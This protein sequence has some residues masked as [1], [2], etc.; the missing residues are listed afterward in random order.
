[1]DDALPFLAIWPHQDQIALLTPNHHGT[2]ARFPPPASGTVWEASPLAALIP[3]LPQPKEGSRW[4]LFLDAELPA[5]WHH[6]PWET[7]QLQGKPLSDHALIVR[8]GRFVPIADRPW[9]TLPLRCFDAFPRHEYPFAE[10]LARWVRERRLRHVTREALR[11]RKIPVDTPL[12]VLAHGSPTGLRDRHGAELDAETYFTHIERL[13]LLACNHGALNALVD[14]LLQWG[15]KTVVAATDLLDAPTIAA[16]LEAYLEACASTPPEPARWLTQRLPTAA[17]GGIERLTLWGEIPLTQRWHDHYWR[18]LRWG[19]ALPLDERCSHEHF[20]QAFALWQT[21]A[22]WPI[23]RETLAP[24]L[25]WLAEKF[26]HGAIRPLERAV[27]QSLAEDPRPERFH[28]LANSAR[29]FG[30][31]PRA[32][33]YLLTGLEHTREDESGRGKLLGA[34]I[35]QLI[36]WDLPE[37]AQEL[38]NH[39]HLIDWPTT[40]QSA[41]AQ[42]RYLDFTARTQ[43]RL[44]QPERALERLAKKRR[45]AEQ[46]GETGQREAA[47]ALYAA[48]WYARQHPAFALTGEWAWLAAAMTEEIPPKAFTTA[49]GNDTLL[50]CLRAQAA[51]AWQQARAGDSRLAMHLARRYAAA[52]RTA[53]KQ[54]DPGPAAYFLLYLAL[55]GQQ[56]PDDAEERALEAL[57]DARYLLE[58]ALFAAWLGKTDTAKTYHRRFAKVR[59]QSAAKVLNHPQVSL[60]ELNKHLCPDAIAIRE[61]QEAESFAD[62][63]VALRYGTLPL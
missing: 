38:C 32:V 46:L 18:H 11:A 55:S 35:N 31:Y 14:Q 53:L 49:K 2:V 19:E 63:L 23:V 26:D 54:E 52:A 17:C 48:A 42:L 22:L 58:S 15:V 5:A 20:A 3:F 21:T 40:E 29:R 37:A 44:G 1:M 9:A 7:T 16:L 28:A 39:Y 25:L 8:R 10:R 60:F 43:L 61:A 34:L 4:L 13:W 41:Q 51:W 56:L 24:H 62:P 57:F 6:A 36:D 47:S 50:Y 33:R 27:E 30:D 45:C 12:V 59:R